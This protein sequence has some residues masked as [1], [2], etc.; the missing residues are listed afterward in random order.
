[1]RP[2]D[3]IPKFLDRLEAQEHE[4]VRPLDGALCETIRWRMGHQEN[5]F[6]SQQADDDLEELFDALDEY[7]PEGYY[8]G[9]HPGDGADYGYWEVEE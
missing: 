1:M 2:E 3:L 6:E 9:A 8:F 7:A 5:Y 4:K